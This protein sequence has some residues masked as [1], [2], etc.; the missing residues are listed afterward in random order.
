HLLEAADVS[1]GERVVDVGCGSGQTT[2]AVA[3][4]ARHGLALGVDLSRPLL[5]EA[6]RRAAHEGLTNAHFEQGDVQ[7]HPF[8]SAHYDAAMSRFGV[9]FFEAPTV[10]FAN[11]AGAVRPG[12]RL[13]FLCWQDAA[14]NEWFTTPGT[15]LAAHLDVPEMSGDEPGPFSLADPRR[16]REHLNGAG[17]IDVSIAPIAEPM[18]WGSDV[19]DVLDFIRNRGRMRDLLADTDEITMR[20][21]LDSMRAALRPYQSTDGVLLGGAAWLVTAHRP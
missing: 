19:D 3:R 4:A 10:A 17:F 15:A 5:D 1:A 14:H 9:M 6:R 12:G 8:A 2:C 11:I 7:V 20:K 18:R 16:I 21:A 13:V